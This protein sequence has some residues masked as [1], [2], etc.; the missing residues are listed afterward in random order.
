MFNP[1][2]HPYYQPN[3]K[4]YLPFIND[5]SVKYFSNVMSVSAKCK[6]SLEPYHA[7]VSTMSETCN[8]NLISLSIQMHLVILTNSR[9]KT[10]QS[11]YKFSNLISF[12]YI[13]FTS[14][15]C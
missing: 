15:F 3:L 6:N 5:M 4:I 9:A 13:N 7:H 8:N 14:T 10:E 2:A 12:F 1:A 11:R